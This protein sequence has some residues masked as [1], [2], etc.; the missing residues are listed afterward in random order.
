MIPIAGIP[1]FSQKSQ[2][3]IQENP[4][5]R[6]D[7]SYLTGAN[8]ILMPQDRDPCAPEWNLNSRD[9]CLKLIRDTICGVTL[10]LRFSSENL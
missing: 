3:A 7:Y 1:N 6:I 9:V 2:K 5:F 10:Q 8:A 4:E